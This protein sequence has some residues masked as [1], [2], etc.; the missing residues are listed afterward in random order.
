MVH[1]S[2]AHFLADLF[3]EGDECNSEHGCNLMDRLLLIF[4]VL[5]AEVKHLLYFEN[6]A[7]A[8]ISACLNNQFTEGGCL[9]IWNQLAQKKSDLWF[10][11]ILVVLDQNPS[12]DVRFSQ[13]KANQ[14]FPD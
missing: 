2:Q 12:S 9:F 4:L 3:T 14:N 7:R 1:S 10:P 11:G 13:G 5:G 8:S 6:I